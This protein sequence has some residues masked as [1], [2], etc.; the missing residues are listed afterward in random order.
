L[1]QRRDYSDVVP[2]RDYSDVVPRRDY[3]DVVPRRD[4]SD[5][6]PRRDYSDV[7]PKKRLFRCCAKEEIVQ[8]YSAPGK[9]GITGKAHIL[10]ADSSMA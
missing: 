8:S 3:S 1:C 6:V 2:R 10:V 9:H 7:V 4:Y 5:V